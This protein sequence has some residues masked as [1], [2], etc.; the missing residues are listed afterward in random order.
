MVVAEWFIRFSWK[1]RR[2]SLEKNI[3]QFSF[4]SLL[5]SCKQTSRRI[6]ADFPRKFVSQLWIRV[7]R[8]QYSKFIYIQ[9]LKYLKINSRLFFKQR[10]IPKKLV[11]KNLILLFIVS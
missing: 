10:N 9:H 5:G 1:H 2:R 3:S 4:W 8:A 6:V 11:K 7:T